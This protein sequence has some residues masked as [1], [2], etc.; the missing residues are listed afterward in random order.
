MYLYLYLYLYSNSGDSIESAKCLIHAFMT[1]LCIGYELLDNFNGEC[2][3]YL[4]I[5]KIIQFSIVGAFEL[6]PF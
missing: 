4:V 3:M 5:E 1:R 2:L 6:E